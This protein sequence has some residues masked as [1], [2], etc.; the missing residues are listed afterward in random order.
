MHT[1]TRCMCPPPPAL[2][3]IHTQS[4]TH[5]H[6]YIYYTHTH[7]LSNTH[8]HIFTFKHTQTCTHTHTH[9]VFLHHSQCCT[10]WKALLSHNHL[11]KWLND[12]R[13]FFNRNRS[14]IN[15]YTSNKDHSTINKLHLFMVLANH[16][17]LKVTATSPLS[18]L[19]LSCLFTPYGTQH[20]ESNKHL[21]LYI[22]CTM[23]RLG[24]MFVKIWSTAKAF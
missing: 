17:K 14:N 18:K 16:I 24:C 21:V 1:N 8:T 9:T 23:A 7:L 12:L 3:H 20:D 2:P 22:I 19:K 10:F 11:R 13:S 15:L 6:S 4:Y 5:S